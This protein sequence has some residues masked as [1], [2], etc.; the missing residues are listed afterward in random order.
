MEASLFFSSSI[1]VTIGAFTIGDFFLLNKQTTEEMKFHFMRGL[2]AWKR[3]GAKQIFGDLNQYLNI[4]NEL[5]I[6]CAVFS[7]ALQK[8][9]GSYFLREATGLQ[10]FPPR[11]KG[12]T[13][14]VVVIWFYLFLN[15]GQQIKKKSHA[16]EYTLRKSRGK[17]NN[18]AIILQ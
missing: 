16:R 3:F 7:E 2:V 15:S 4:E 13:C 9:D 6:Q 17:K 14:L 10:V 1:C 18:P 5:N 12:R 8:I 11:R